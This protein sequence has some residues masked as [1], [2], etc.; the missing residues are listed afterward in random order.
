MA[1]FLLFIWLDLRI[2]LIRL[3]E[4]SRKNGKH[5]I[6]YIGH[7]IIVRY[8]ST[9]IVLPVN[10]FQAARVGKEKYGNFYFT[11]EFGVVSTLLVY[12]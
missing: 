4:R 12:R 7:I 9:C 2:V 10:Q 6:I 5:Q 3:P 8:I 11:G 1:Q